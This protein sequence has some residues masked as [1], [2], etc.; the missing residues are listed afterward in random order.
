MERL[1][2]QYAAYTKKGSQLHEDFVKLVG[3]FMEEALSKYDAVDVEH[4][5]VTAI[6]Y[7]CSFHRIKKGVDVR[8][9]E[10]E[11]KEKKDKE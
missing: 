9:A 3:G 10:I 5:L 6:D 1:F 8:K 4:I 2:N 11:E 7:K